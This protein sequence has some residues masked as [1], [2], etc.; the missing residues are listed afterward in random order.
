MAQEW[1]RHRF[2]E[3]ERISHKRRW[4]NVLYI[5]YSN[6]FLY[7][8]RTN[9]FWCSPWEETSQK[10][11]SDMDGQNTKVQ[12]WG[13]HVHAYILYIPVALYIH[14]I[15]TYTMS[16]LCTYM[17]VMLYVF[18]VYMY[19]VHDYMYVCV[20][21]C[22]HTCTCMYMYTYV[23]FYVQVHVC[24]YVWTEACTFYVHVCI[25]YILWCYIVHLYTCTSIIIS[26]VRFISTYIGHFKTSFMAESNAVQC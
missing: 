15:L 17:Y 2:W 5:L 24:M 8:F 9:R 16:T 19:S 26:I 10:I 7:V 23:G 20:H 25:T 18:A 6:L 11:F 3:V 1:T 13:L 21:A 14:Y 12:R 22:I 4:D